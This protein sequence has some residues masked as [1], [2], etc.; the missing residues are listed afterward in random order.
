MLTRIVAVLC[1]APGKRQQNI[2]KDFFWREAKIG[3][4]SAHM[5]CMEAGRGALR[6]QDPPTAVQLYCYRTGRYG[7][8]A[9]YG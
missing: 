1:P 7:R 5:F 3:G 8:T 9:P 2:Y 4:F 6:L